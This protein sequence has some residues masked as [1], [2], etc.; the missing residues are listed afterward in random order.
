MST[1]GY[2]ESL[3]GAVPPD[4]KKVLKDIFQYVLPNGRFGPVSHQAKAENFSAGYVTSTT[5]STANTEFSVVHGLGRTPYL[6]T[7]ITPLDAVGAAAVRLQVT[8][9]ADGNR[10]YLRSPDTSAVIYLYLE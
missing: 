2:V 3:L 6:F 8:R 9:A 1:P 4:L 5:P 7:Q 10:V